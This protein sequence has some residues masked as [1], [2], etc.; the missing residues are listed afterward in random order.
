MDIK[1][2]P[3]LRD[4]LIPGIG[5]Q[6]DALI[7]WRSWDR[8]TIAR[9]A[10][11]VIVATVAIGLRVWGINQLGYNTDEAVYAGQAAAIASP[12]FA[13]QDA[14]STTNDQLG[15]V[16]SLTDR[17]VTAARATACDSSSRLWRVV[18]RLGG[19]DSLSAA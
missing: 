16:V 13:G 4:R 6:R 8:A 10:G 18:A 9:I 12:F 15:N 7:N 14:G 2:V 19:H 11:I 5:S 17:A 3:S 1:N